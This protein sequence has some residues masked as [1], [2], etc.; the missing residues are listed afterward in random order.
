MLQQEDAAVTV[1]IATLSREHSCSSEVDRKSDVFLILLV[2]DLKDIPCSGN[3]LAFQAVVS[4]HSAD[5]KN[6]EA[7]LEVFD[8]HPESAIV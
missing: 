8:A 3:F 2:L 1:A 7:H 6:A 5:A 4:L